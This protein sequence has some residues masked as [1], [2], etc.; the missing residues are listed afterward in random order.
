MRILYAVL[1]ML[2]FVLV[3]ARGSQLLYSADGSFA[4]VLEPLSLHING[5][6]YP[7]SDLSWNGFSLLS[8]SDLSLGTFPFGSDPANVYVMAIANGLQEVL[9]ISSDPG[10][11]TRVSLGANSTG[12]FLY[13]NAGPFQVNG[14]DDNA[15]NSTAAGSLT[16]RGGEKSAGTGNG[17]DLTLA[18]G[19][20]SGGTPGSVL[21]KDS[22]GVNAINAE[23]KE[24]R[25]S[26]GVV[27]DWTNYVLRDAS[28]GFNALDWSAKI[29]YD[30]ANGIS[31]NWDGRSLL[32]PNGVEALK[33]DTNDIVVV[34]R[35]LS[36]AVAGRQVFV[37]EGVNSLSQTCTLVAGTCT[38][39]N[40]NITAN[41]RIQCTGQSDGGTP[42]FL[43]VST[44]SNGV[45]YTVTSSS[46][47]DT[48]LVACFIVEGI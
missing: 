11:Q 13:S 23:T 8:A 36:I 16:I 47:A 48:S 32:F 38:I 10:K 26:L 44:R 4:P 24:L 22:A 30:V 12:N 20:S 9:A 46:V 40:A 6:N 19:T 18:P 31:I 5:D 3:P 34:N 17:G 39:S 42:G 7:T 37:Q 41:S 45:S 27:L 35:D 15:A 28:T 14:S 25:D 2:L 1:L 43:R 21:V 33:W 29:L